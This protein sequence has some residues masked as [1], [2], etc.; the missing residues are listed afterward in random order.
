MTDDERA[1]IERV[2]AVLEA[3]ARKLRAANGSD[4]HTRNLVATNIWYSVNDLRG[5]CEL[6]KR[7]WPVGIGE[8]ES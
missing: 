4:V 3:Q 1:V 5:V 8:L 7:K 6:P 2:I